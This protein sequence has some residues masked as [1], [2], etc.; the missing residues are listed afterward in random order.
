MNNDQLIKQ[1]IIFDIVIAHSGIFVLR[2]LRHVHFLVDWLL[3]YVHYLLYP[4]RIL[5]G[6]RRL[7]GVPVGKVHQVLNIKRTSWILLDMI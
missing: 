5:L 4:Y 6:F 2:C 3:D 1:P 7:D